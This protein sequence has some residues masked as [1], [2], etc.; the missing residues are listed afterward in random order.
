MKIELPVSVKKQFCF[1]NLFVF[2]LLQKPL[3][4]TWCFIFAPHCQFSYVRVYSSQFNDIFQTCINYLIIYGY[5][6]FCT[7]SS[8]FLLRIF[9]ITLNTPFSIFNLENIVWKTKS[10]P[11]NL[12][13]YIAFFFL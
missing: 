1:V 13:Q 10:L 12:F 3:T 7:Y 9:T 6:S 8:N 2:F 4:K 11:K 5:F